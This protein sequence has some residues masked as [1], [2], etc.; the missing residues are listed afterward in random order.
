[1]EANP[2]RTVLLIVNTHG[3]QILYVSDESSVTATD[4]IP[5][6]SNGNLVM[7]KALGWEPGKKWYVIASGAATTGVV[8]EA[9]G[10]LGGATP[11]G[12]PAPTG[13]PPVVGGG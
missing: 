1:M 4:G 9:F 13:T 3:A 6:R 2:A 8:Y 12:I 10:V 11:P 5:I 7:E